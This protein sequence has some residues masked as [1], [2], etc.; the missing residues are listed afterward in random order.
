MSDI[1][2]MHSNEIFQERA[3]TEFKENGYKM[4]DDYLG[5]YTADWMILP[6]RKENPRR[7]VTTWT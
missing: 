7:V 6:N 1:D 4:S 5:K 2:K 3:K